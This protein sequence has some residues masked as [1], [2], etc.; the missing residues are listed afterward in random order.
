MT[1]FMMIFMGLVFLITIPLAIKIKYTEY[2]I[3]K[4]QKQKAAAK[5]T[6]D[7]VQEALA[8]LQL[9]KNPS[10]TEITQAHK[11]LMRLNHPDAGGSIYM[12]TKINVARDIL[13]SKAA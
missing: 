3:R 4:L 7:K 8:V 9:R 1:K 6:H 2:Q 11:K 12:A 5:A 13:M 10:K